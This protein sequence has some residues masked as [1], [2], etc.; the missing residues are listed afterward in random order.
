ML[1]CAP[2]AILGGQGCVRSD[3]DRAG[4]R[5]LALVG[6]GAPPL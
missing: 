3:Q 6:P 4:K 5:A 2:V 1:L